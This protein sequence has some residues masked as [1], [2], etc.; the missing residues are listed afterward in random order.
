[1]GLKVPVVVRLAGTNH[2]EA[3]VMLKNSG[4]ALIVA[5]DLQ[6][7]ARKAVNAARGN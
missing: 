6:D 1:V 7:A 3:A 4:I 5:H 2:E